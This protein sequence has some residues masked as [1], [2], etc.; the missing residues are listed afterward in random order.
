[1]WEKCE[2]PLASIHIIQSNNKCP[3]VNPG[4]KRL[5]GGFLKIIE[6]L[7]FKFEFF[8]LFTIVVADPY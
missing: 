6:L 5:V 7:L 8:N 1:M 4:P 2:K 3:K